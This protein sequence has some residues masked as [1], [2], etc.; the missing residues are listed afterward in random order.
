MIHAAQDI[1]EF[2][3][4]N[5]L[6]VFLIDDPSASYVTCRT[7]VRT[8]SINEAAFLGAGASHYLE[9]LLAGGTTT[10]RKEETY[11]KLI[12]LFGGAFNAY[13]TA[14]HTSYFINTLPKDAPEAISI[15]SEWMF[16]SAFD[17][18]E[19]N[20]ER[21]VIIKEI[22]KNEANLHRKFYQ[23]AQESFYKYSPQGYPVIGYVENFK[24]LNMTDIQSY[25]RTQYVPSNMALIIGGNI[26]KAAIMARIQATF[27]Q[28]PTHATPRSAYVAE[29]I[30]FSQRS[31]TYE[32]DTHVTYLSVRFPSVDI[33]SQELSA[34]DLLEFILGKGEDSLLNKTLV[35]KKKLA[36]SVGVSSYTPANST[37]FFDISFETDE[38][39]IEPLKKELFQILATISKGKLD[40]KMIAKAKKQKLAEDILSIST[41][42]DKAEKLGQSYIYG[43]SKDFFDHYIN[44]FKGV[45]KAQVILAA[46]THFIPEH[47][48]ITILRPKQEIKSS[49]N[50]E[51]FSSILVKKPRLIS[52]KNGIRV[53]LYHDTS[54]PKVHAKVFVMGGLRAEAPTRNGVGMLLSEMLGKTSAHYSKSR[55]FELIEGNGAHM[56]ASLGVHTFYYSLE[57]VSDDFEALFPVFTDT[58]LH[59]KFA[60]SDLEESKR[61]LTKRLSQREDD[62]YSNGSYQFKKQFFGTHPYG[63][64]ALGEPQ[65]VSGLTCEDIQSHYH[66]MMNPTQMV[67]SV[68]GDFDEEKILKQIEEQFSS[69]KPNPKGF[70]A[71]QVIPR[72]RHTKKIE[73]V[74]SIQQDVA[75]LFIGFDS[76]TFKEKED[77]LKLDLVDAVLTGAHYP[78]GRLHTQLREKGYVYMVHGNNV[79]G[80]EPGYVVLCALTSADKIDSVKSIIFDHIKDI[81]E[82]LITD[83]EFTQ[84][85]AQLHFYNKDRIASLEALAVITATDELYQN[86]YDYFTQF[87]NQVRLLTKEDVQTAA[88]AYLKNPQIFQFIGKKE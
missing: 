58:F 84:A 52:L 62:W 43:Y 18:K 20:R 61:K 56:G 8:G 38:K 23:Y 27:G 66:Y 24:K 45:T 71:F 41:I 6:K 22:E 87:D 10:K 4:D 85:I 69:V 63:L 1:S 29:P 32:G 42:E 80:L 78:G 64:S 11:K 34:I 81:Q 33:Y 17:E 68:F 13:T 26:D 21:D 77:S 25:Y 35:L 7:Y 14:D 74:I 75:A 36:Y 37:G 44:R 47:A 57:T 28:V 16:D 70:K 72:D 31:M 12:S 51:T 46:K 3:L 19:F 67:V 48:T 59:P 5:G 79:A 65:S 53:L 2:T 15:L 82:H 49:R 40:E 86:G 54:L 55:I 39:T 60:K 73:K 9:H 76:T 83:D 50:I 88:K 30:P